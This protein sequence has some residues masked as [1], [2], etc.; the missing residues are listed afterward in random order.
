MHFSRINSD[1]FSPVNLWTALGQVCRY[2]LKLKFY[3]EAACIKSFALSFQFSHAHEDAKKLWKHS[4][5][6]SYSLKFA[7]CVFLTMKFII[8]KCLWIELFLKGMH[9]AELK[10]FPLGIPVLPALPSVITHD[11]LVHQIDPLYVL[12]IGLL[13]LWSWLNR[14]KKGL[15]SIILVSKYSA[16]Y[17]KKGFTFVIVRSFDSFVRS[18][19]DSNFTCE[20]TGIAQ[21]TIRISMHIPV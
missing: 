1:Y 15:F 4:P 12:L 19:Q 11:S 18:Q 14:E 7:L 16:C 5:L 17:C 2:F 10:F 21:V 6:G 9:F 20:G 13:D 8:S 3:D